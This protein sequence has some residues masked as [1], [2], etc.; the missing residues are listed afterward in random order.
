[1]HPEVRADRPGSCP[2]CGML[3]VAGE[4]AAAHGDHGHHA[5]H[6]HPGQ[7]PHSHRGKDGSGGGGSHD[8]VPAGHTGVVYTCP[9]HPAVRR[10]EPGSCPL[11]GMGLEPESGAMDEDAPN[12]ELVDFTRRFRV[13][14]ALTVPLLVLTM[15]PF[16]GFGVVREVFGERI[17]L[18]IEVVLGTPVVLW[19]GLPFLARGWTSFRTW[20][21]NMFSLIAMGVSAA[22]LYSM[23]AVLA[24]GIFPDGF[25]DAEGHVGVYFEAAAV[26]VTLVLLGQLMELRA[27][28]GAGRAIR[29]L[30]DLAAKTALVVRGD[31]LE[32]DVPLDEVQPGDRLRVRPG[33]KV[34]VDGLVVEG[35]SFVDESMITGEPIPVEKTPGDPVTGATINGAG[36]LIMEAQRVGAG[37]VLSQIVEM[38]ANAQRSRAPIQRY[39]DRVAGL[40]CRW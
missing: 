7:H 14:A 17:A 24:P 34:P 8:T 20:N 10:T 16:L 13:G 1:M 27:R 26:I 9:M 28:Q 31:G 40:S 18:W 39:A 29:A 3:L 2:K 21:L 6:G 38:V 11:C 25:R 19:C 23:V 30:L 12:P 5:D 4:E 37:T 33:D 35:R 32:E 22:W 15:A 36:S